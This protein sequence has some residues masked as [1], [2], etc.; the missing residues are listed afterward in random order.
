MAKAP[1]EPATVGTTESRAWELF[2]ASAN[3]CGVATT[4]HEH[5]AREC[6]KAAKAFAEV[7]AT[8]SDN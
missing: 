2:A 1:K 4:T 6:F 5:L 7:A 3:V 8:E